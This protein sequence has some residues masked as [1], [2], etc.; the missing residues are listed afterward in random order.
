MSTLSDRVGRKPIFLMAAIVDSATG[1]LIGLIPNNWVFITM[2][3]I[4]G[5]GDNSMATGYS[6][7]ADYVVSTPKGHSGSTKDGWF[8]RTFYRIIRL[9]NS[10]DEENYMER[11]L[12]LQYTVILI[13]QT[14]GLLIGVVLGDLLYMAT[15]SYAIS[16][17]CSGFIYCPNILYIYCYM[18]ETVPP[19]RRK[20]LSW[21]GLWHATVIQW[22]SIFLFMGHHRLWPLAIVNFLVQFVSAGVFDVVLYWGEWKFGWGTD[23]EAVALYISI[24]AGILGAVVI[25]RLMLSQGVSYSH[26]LATMCFISAVGC[27]PSGFSTSNL[28]IMFSLLMVGVGFG[29]LPGISA[30]IANEATAEEQGRVNGFNY[31]ISTAAWAS[32]PYAYWY[33]YVVYVD[34]DDSNDV[35][36]THNTASSLLW[37]V[38]SGIFFV[39]GMIMMFVK[40]SDGDKL[41]HQG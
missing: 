14:C 18:P 23:M 8:T 12:G 4:Q 13:I 22:D 35:T 2:M 19:S 16:I 24:F 1:M 21:A 10:H 25:P 37:W 36:H 7:L 6:L 5:A 9:G 41:K 28:Q 26:M 11:E 38:T 31:A 17:A 29:A 3:M 15:S 39:A 20:P 33:M 40:D 27:I 32:G 34:D 30:Q